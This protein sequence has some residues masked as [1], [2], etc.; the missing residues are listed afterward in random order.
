MVTDAELYADL[1]EQYQDLAAGM[2]A[3]REA[4]E[5]AFGATLPP[6]AT[7]DQELEIITR[8]AHAIA[9]RPSPASPDEA[10]QDADE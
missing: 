1:W 10:G 4:M 2:R 8:T 9:K 6:S 7:L 5:H 3:I